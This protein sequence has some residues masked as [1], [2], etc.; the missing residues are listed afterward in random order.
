[1]TRYRLPLGWCVL[2]AIGLVAGSA[3]AAGTLDRIRERHAVVFAYRDGAAPFSFKDS[4]GVVRGYSVD[5]CARIA[6]AL[7]RRLGIAPLA[8]EW[9]PVNADTRIDAVASGRADAECGTTTISL[10]RMERVDFSVPIF[11]D[12][13]TLLVPGKAA[14]KRLADLKG[15]RIAVIS[16]TT[17]ERAL[18]AALDV[19]E[20]PATLVAVAKPEEGAEAVRAGRADAFAGDRLVLIQLL[21]RD[22]PAAFRI[23]D[24]DFSFEPYGIVVRRD[25]ADFRLVVNRA[26]VDAYKKGDIDAIFQRWLAPLGKPSPLLNA[27]FYLNALPE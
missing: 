4:T 19:A 18:R 5:L 11:V 25:D 17:T 21:T 20:A 9:M 6:A 22:E 23:L 7:E 24:D 26:L 12:G 10:S 15:R 8:I 16:G 14:V 2:V 27:M 1:M 13:G 3:Q